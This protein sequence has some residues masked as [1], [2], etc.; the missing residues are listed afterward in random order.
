VNSVPSTGNLEYLTNGSE[1]AITGRPHQRTW[2]DGKH[3]RERIKAFAD[4]TALS[5]ST[6][7][8]TTP[9]TTT[10][11]RSTAPPRGRVRR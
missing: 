2:E 4:P 11:P 3:K 9:R 7:P 5:Y 8:P 6:L 10:P 1:I